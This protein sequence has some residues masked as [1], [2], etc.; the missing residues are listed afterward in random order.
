MKPGKKGLARIIAATRY[1]W[2]GLVAAWN[3]EAAFRQ[4]VILII[5]LMP[6]AFIIGKSA[7]QIAIMVLSLGLVLIA[8]LANSAIEAVVDR[9]GGEQHELSGR[10]KDIGSAMVLISLLFSCI[11]WLTI[12]YYNYFK[13]AFT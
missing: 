8:E 7:S 11:T 1:S 2:Q 6:L 10:A 4:E 12:V 3:N 9:F 5:L 13:V